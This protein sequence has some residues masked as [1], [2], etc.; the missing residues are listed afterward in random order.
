[1]HAA[2]E[3]LPRE[4]PERLEGRTAIH[5]FDKFWEMM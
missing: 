3:G 4:V 1:M 2:Y 5:D